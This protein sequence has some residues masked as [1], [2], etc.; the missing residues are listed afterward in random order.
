MPAPR[1]WQLSLLAGK[2][3][4][5]VP[6]AAPALL[7]PLPL[8]SFLLPLLFLPLPPPALPL[9]VLL[10]SALTFSLVQTPLS[11]QLLHCLPSAFLQPDTP[12]L[13]FWLH[14]FQM[15]GNR[16]SHIRS[17]HLRK[18]LSIQPLF[19]PHLQLCCGIVFQQLRFLL[20]PQAVHQS[21]HP[22]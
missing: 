14:P 10:Q 21:P 18:L 9:F 3:V 19:L 12:D 15:Q 1:W 16:S 11:G 5:L 8:L 4:L 2:P 20:L 6:A 7:P 17:P 13:P 22:R